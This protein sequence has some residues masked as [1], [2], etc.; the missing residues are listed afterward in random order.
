MGY[1]MTLED[2]I[3]FIA[4]EN[5][6][7]IIE[8]GQKLLSN[9]FEKGSGGSY[10]DGIALEKN[11][12]WVDNKELAKADTVEKLFK[13][14]RWSAIFNENGD[15]IAVEFDG[16]KLGDDEF[17]FQEIAPWVKAGSYVEM[18]GEDGDRWRWVFNDGKCKE[19]KAKIVWE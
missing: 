3:F 9:V 10:R 13:A 19:K 2:C 6:A 1:Y 15:I 16:E 11:Y 7:H 8:A 5:F 12:S 17:F 14:W 4:K 18:L